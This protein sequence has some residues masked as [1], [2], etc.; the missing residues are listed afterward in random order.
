MEWIDSASIDA[1]P[2]TAN[3]KN[4]EMAIPRLA[5]NAA[6]TARRLP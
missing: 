2:V 4:L 1:E 5:R 6:M 3:A